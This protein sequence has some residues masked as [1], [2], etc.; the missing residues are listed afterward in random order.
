M[1]KPNI[2]I[3]RRIHSLMFKMPLMISC[4]EFEDFILDYLNGNL[5]SKQNFIFEMHIKVCREC[6][7][8]LKAYRTSME[9]AKQALT[10][11]VSPL[12]GEV[13]EDLVKAVMAARKT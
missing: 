10:E 1:N 5:P 2:P 11:D 4:E 7:D 3:R 8:Y 9:L 6:R 12:P 13:P